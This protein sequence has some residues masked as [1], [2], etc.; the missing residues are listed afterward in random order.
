V[1]CLV[2]GHR[3][4]ESKPLR[5][6]LPP[7]RSTRHLDRSLRAGRHFDKPAGWN[8]QR[9]HAAPLSGMLRRF[10]VDGRQIDQGLGFVE[11]RGVAIEVVVGRGR[12]GFGRAGG[13]VGG[14]WPAVGTVVPGDGSW[15]RW[16]CGERSS[17]LGALKRLL[18]LGVGAAE[19]AG[20]FERL[21]LRR[22]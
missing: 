5:I 6:R 21:G 12:A 20:G 16:W 15:Y 3:V 18:L 10:L 9:N 1:G 11:L 22:W 17:G 2:L 13:S 19:E 14:A 8:L 4:S 7:R